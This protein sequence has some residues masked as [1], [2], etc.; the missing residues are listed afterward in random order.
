MMHDL[1]TSSVP[2]YRQL[3]VAPMLDY[4]DRLARYFLRLFARDVGLYSEMVTTSALIHGACDRMLR[5]HDAEQPVILQLGGSD[6][7]ELALCARMA[8]EAGYREVNLNVGCPSD[9]VQNGR[10]GACLMAEPQR[11]AE[12]FAAM[13]SAVRIPV[14]IKHRLGIDG[15][16]RW[17]ELVDF[18]RWQVEAGCQHLIVHA[19]IAILHGLSPKENREIPPLRYEWVYALKKQFPLVCI[20]LNGGIRRVEEVSSHLHQVDGVMIGREAYHNPWILAESA[21]RLW[22]EP[23]PDREAILEHYRL[24]M[25]EEL[26]AGTPLARMSRHILGLYQGQP[27]ARAWRQ[28]LSSG[29]CRKGAGLEVIDQALSAMR[30]HQSHELEQATVIH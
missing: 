5:F 13:Q 22:A 1:N 27:G 18:V 15:R 3:S 30:R 21:A 24:F 6:P 19:R 10:M 25:I 26:A 17:E 7:R 23:L 4:T 9:R 2:R 28:H 14:S 29:V 12:C 11:V 8:E 20:V 16:D